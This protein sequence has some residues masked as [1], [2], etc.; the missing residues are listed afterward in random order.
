VNQDRILLRSLIAQVPI[1]SCLRHPTDNFS[2]S[3]PWL[4]LVHGPAGIITQLILILI[5]VS[6]I[7]VAIYKLF[8]F[9]RYS[10]WELS[11][12][13]VCLGLDLTSSASN[14]QYMSVYNFLS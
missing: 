7:V 10:G 4:S 1:D 9:V 12:T 11:V 13:Q 14:V 6:T 3:N 8:R 2:D 5:L